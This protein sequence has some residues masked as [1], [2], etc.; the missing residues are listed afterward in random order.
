MPDA[1][2]P[3]AETSTALL[4]GGPPPAPPKS[5]QPSSSR[6]QIAPAEIPGVN[7]LLT[8]AVSVVVIAALYFARDVLVPIT[9]AVLLSFVLA[10]VVELMQRIRVP[11]AP[12]VILAVLLAL[13]VI[14]ATGSMIATQLANLA[15]ELPRYQYTISEKVDTVRAMTIGRISRVVG[16][17]GR[18][19]EAASKPDEAAAPAAPT[20]PT[21][22][23][24]VPVEV[25]APSLT[26]M[27]MATAVLKPALKPVET[28]L[29]VLLVTVFILLQREDLRDRMIRLFGS[30]DLHRTTV[31]LD[32]AGQRLSRYFLFQ[33]GLNTLFGCVITAALFAIGMPSPLLFGIMAGLLRFVPYVGSVLAA[34]LP[35]LL[36]AAVDP[37]WNM[38]LWTVAL[39]AI[40]EPLMGQVVEPMVYGH[41]TGLSPVSVVIAAIF[42]TWLWGPIGLL[43][44]TPLTLCLVVLGRHVDRLE[45]LDVMLGDRPALTPVE[46]FYQRMLAGD[47]DEAHDQADQLLKERP[48][49]SYYDEVALTG[50]KLAAN[51]ATR[52]VLNDAQVERIKNAICELVE[53]LGSQHKDSQPGGNAADIAPTGLTLAE[54]AVPKAPPPG[55]GEADRHTLADRWRTPRAVLCV[56]GRGPLDEAANAMLAQLLA[57]HGVGVEQAPHEA[58]SRAHIGRLDPAGIA[59]VC[60]S[61]LEVTGTP[62]HLRYLLR[63]VRQRLPGVPI[64]VGLW[65]AEDA[66]LKDDRL[67]TVLGADHYVSSLRDAVN[68]CLEEAHK[69]D[70]PQQA[71]AAAAA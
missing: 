32:E 27:E 64:L 17:I 66:T 52:G 35:I 11:R 55:Q 43:L 19:V 45:F 57:K 24:P 68:A 3:D 44:S 36:A 67:R 20:A 38:V 15:E 2:K 70:P 9:L 65:P 56:A 14:L 10:P 30:K 37:G 58:V 28:I 5:A 12:S 60:I 50:L 53:D 49:S 4:A 51:D 42:W 40:T 26:P 21:A 18:Q 46:S 34:A 54:K 31:A 25:R 69:D 13:G 47:P 62:T 41:S 6:V 22:A 7:S 39:F 8:L 71:Q 59:M 33:L 1:G 48:L 23:P 29:I 61:Y 16:N 63:R